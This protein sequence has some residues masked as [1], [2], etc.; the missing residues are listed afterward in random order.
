MPKGKA[1]KLEEGQNVKDVFG[2]DTDSDEELEDV[3]NDT[4]HND[5]VRYSSLSQ[6]G[7][8]KIINEQGF[9]LDYSNFN[10]EGISRGDYGYFVEVRVKDLVLMII[11]C[12]KKRN[13][14]NNKF[15]EPQ[16]T[17]HIR[18][19]TR[20]TEKKLRFLTFG[21][22]ADIASN[23]VNELIEKITQAHPYHLLEFTIEKKYVIKFISHDLDVSENEYIRAVT[24][25]Q[26]YKSI[27]A[28]PEWIPYQ[29]FF[30]NELLK[31]DWAQDFLNYITQEK[32][33][34]NLDQYEYDIK[35]RHTTEGW[36]QVKASKNSITCYNV[37][38]MEKKFSANTVGW[39]ITMFRSAIGHQLLTYPIEM[40]PL[41][42]FLGFRLGGRN[43]VYKDRGFVN[44]IYL[45]DPRRNEYITPR[46]FD[47]LFVVPLGFNRIK[48]AY[49]DDDPRD[50]KVILAKD[51]NEI[52]DDRVAVIDGSDS[53][54]FAKV[55]DADDYKSFTHA[56]LIPN[57][58]SFLTMKDKD[59]N[60][61]ASM[62][63]YSFHDV[64]GLIET[65]VV[66]IC[67]KA[68][69]R[70]KLLAHLFR[71]LAGRGGFSRIV[72]TS[73]EEPNYVLRMIGLEE[74]TYYTDK[75]ALYGAYQINL[76]ISV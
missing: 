75:G 2:I 53:S 44:E 46:T 69:E 30:A 76:N 21:N 19:F 37:A 33:G 34:T 6:E 12:T 18:F 31:Y 52:S 8:E 1:G 45:T 55:C 56:A 71:S 57:R 3:E 38:I 51:V 73:Q 25:K 41:A 7:I 5:N 16:Y 65:R 35:K 20:Q 39:F 10:V 36:I 29:P 62:C 54:N 70:S 61:K 72:L 40:H 63:Y 22:I 11:N 43:N 49:R 26:R 24:K 68:I 9:A 66:K 67:G 14:I 48:H 17:F 47:R 74:E 4:L 27:D 15:T 32:S 60:L 58:L 64:D 50:W 23:G 42:I 13:R 59:N 28:H